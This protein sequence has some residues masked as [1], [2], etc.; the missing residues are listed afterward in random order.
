MTAIFF[1]GASSRRHDVTL[2]F[3]ERLDIRD[4][5][6]QSLAQWAY[7]DLRRGDAPAGSLRISNIAAAPLARLEIRDAQMA[8]ELLAR[9]PLIDRHAGQHS[10]GRI[11]AWSLAAAAS[12]LL[13]ATF[14]LPLI[15]DRLAPLLP[16]A[17]ER[18]LGEVAEQQVKTIFGD[19]VCSDPAG[20]AAFTKLVDR[21]R[22]AG[23]L[24]NSVAPEVVAS[25]I[26]NAIALPGG[27]VVLFSRLLDKADNP[28]EIA[29]V[30]AHEFGHVAHRDNLRGLIRDGGTSFLVGLLF[31]DVTG[32]GALIFAS[33]TLITSSHSREAEAAA[34]SYSIELMQRLGRSPTPMGE[35]LFRITGKEAG[36]GPSILS[37]HPLTE[38]RLARMKALD[39][40][41]HGAPLLSD[42][43]WRALKAICNGPG[44]IERT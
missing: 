16:P 40:P 8:A 11:V 35:L 2:G 44:K 33:R 34:D 39:A 28:D 18:R 29:G 21:F 32:S 27:K 20:Q 36:H 10:A 41:P 24:D 37:S 26:P 3:G 31:G 38:D 23:N 43:E 13:I 9:C 6:D 4:Q 30:L 17:F 42:A 25:E 1:D 7:A 14:G 5:Q 12:V 19:K 22:A 15:A